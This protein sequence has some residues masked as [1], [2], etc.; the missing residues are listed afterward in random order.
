VVKVGTSSGRPQSALIIPVPAAEELVGSE[1]L[2]HDPMAA[3]GVPAHITL[4]VPWVEPARLASDRTILPALVDV[5]ADVKSFDFELTGVGWFDKFG[6][7][8]LWL[9]PE[10]GAV[11]CELTALLADRFGTPPWAGK[12]ADVVPHLTIGHAGAGGPLEPVA[13]L[14][15]PRL[16]IACRAEEVRAMV[17]DGRRW[18]VHARVPLG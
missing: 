14:L 6:Q 12:F 17:G 16:P 2:E 9:A 3:A 1:R 10:P 11:F 18:I 13:E 5:L 15:R 4:I 7:K 8:V